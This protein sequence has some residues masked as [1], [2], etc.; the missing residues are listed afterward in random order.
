M[1]S[2]LA[3]ARHGEALVATGRAAQGVALISEALTV[4][5]DTHYGWERP[6]FVELQLALVRGEIALGRHDRARALL[7]EVR[8]RIESAPAAAGAEWEPVR[9]AVRELANQV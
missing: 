2:A 9:G 7:G 1:R 4:L 8:A 5:A 3:G 6:G